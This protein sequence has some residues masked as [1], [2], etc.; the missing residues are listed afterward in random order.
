MPVVFKDLYKKCSPFECLLIFLFVTLQL[1]ILSFKIRNWP[2]TD[3]PMFS[4]SIPAFNEITTVHLYSIY[5]S[6]PYRWTRNDLNGASSYD[7]KLR[8][9]L[10][11]SSNKNRLDQ[12]FLMKT[13]LTFANNL[14]EKLEVRKIKIFPFH[15]EP[16]IIEET[17]RTINLE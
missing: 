6:G 12:Y 1:A 4:K 15:Q 7:Q 11:D 5:E 14:P 13:K 16:K 3:F 2:F 9:Y 8:Y 10:I 17:I